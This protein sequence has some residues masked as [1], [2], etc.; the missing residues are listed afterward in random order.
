MLPQRLP[1][2]EP[3]YKIGQM[4]FYF[5]TME[6]Y[7]VFS[8]LDVFSSLEVPMAIGKY[9]MIAENNRLFYIQN[10]D[11]LQVQYPEHVEKAYEQWL[12]DRFEKSLLQ[13]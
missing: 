9:Q 3:D 5:S 1:D 13:D 10:S 6:Q 12:N 11:N 7:I 8:G 2:G 4:Y